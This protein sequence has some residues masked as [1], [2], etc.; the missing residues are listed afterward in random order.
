MEKTNEN[1]PADQQ[2]SSAEI[3]VSGK[4]ESKALKWIVDI[5]ISIIAGVTVSLGLHMFS[6][7]SAQFV[8]GGI[9]GIAKI[10][11]LLTN[12]KIGWGWFMLMLNI[13]IFTLEA[14]F[15][16]KRLGLILTVYALAQ[17]LSLELFKKFGVWQYNVSEW[18]RIY[19][20]IA[21]GV[22]TG[23]GF[24]IQIMRH[25]ASGGTYA[26][27]SLV[28]HW[29]PSANIAWLSF[30]MDA[31]V[32][33]LAYFVFDNSVSAV[34]CTFINLFIADIVVDK[35]LQGTK[36][37]YKF[38]IITDEPDEISQLIIKELNHGVTEMTV[39]G[40]YSHKEKYMIVCIIRKR[41]LSKMMR[42]L[43]LYPNT[44]ASFSRVNE[45]FGKFK[46]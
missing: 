5:V 38:E 39:N 29:K 19:A 14:I 3:A 31:S 30:V 11:S 43:R 17:S 10:L 44:F 15:V 6:T 27:S 35:C 7:D 22:V 1:I 36:D 2:N 37:G 20:A 12:N 25:G 9:T 8:P 45:V 13:P 24:S 46:K 28:K 42:I 34:I 23:V 18:E 32:I 4:K 16:N 33:V 41:E 40:M 21:T 26:I